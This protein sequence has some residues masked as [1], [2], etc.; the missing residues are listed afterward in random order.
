MTNIVLVNQG[1]KNFLFAVPEN[2]TLK[3]GDRVLCNTMRGE[4][5]GICATDSFEVDEHALKQIATLTGAYFPLK[6]VIGKSKM[7]KFEDEHKEKTVIKFNVGERYKVGKKAKCDT[8]NVIEIT[9]VDGMFRFY[10]ILSGTSSG[11]DYFHI[12]STFSTHLI[13]YTEEKTDNKETEK[14]KFYNGKVVATK[15]ISGFTKGKIYEFIDGCV[16]DDDGDER[17]RFFNPSPTTNIDEANAMLGA[18][19][20]CIQRG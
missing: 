9:N 3:K 16:T 20:V 10:K 19:F 5:D 11:M 8:G 14:P 2:V 1:G 12:D 13:P 17:P 15:T 18:G 7:V 6:A 4:Q